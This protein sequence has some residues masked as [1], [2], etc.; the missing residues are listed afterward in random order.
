MKKSDILDLSTL[1]HSLYGARQPLLPDGMLQ[2]WY[3]HL[4]RFERDLIMQ[5][6][7]RWAR[8]HTTKAPSLDEILEQAEIL[9][10]DTRRS[11][12]PSTPKG[13][14]EVLKDLAE[15]GAQSPDDR[16]LAR[17]H[18]RLAEQHPRATWAQ[19]CRAWSDHYAAKRP[20]LATWL[21]E[22]S[23]KYEALAPRTQPAPTPQG[24]KVIPL[25]FEARAVASNDAYEEAGVLVS[26]AAA[27]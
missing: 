7:K 4:E 10:E 14:V 27:D 19:Q 20:Q 3:E 13:P 22:A 9:Q 6:V 8:Q 2:L 18:C 1:L 11:R 5:A 24:G 25:M 16:L 15:L 26:D 12:L 23:R 17:L 21:L